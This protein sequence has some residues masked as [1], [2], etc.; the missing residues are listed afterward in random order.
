V[1][2]GRP[3]RRVPGSGHPV[4]VVLLAV[5]LVAA[6]VLATGC[7]HP[8]AGEAVAAPAPSLP[9]RA[10]ELET[11]LV[12]EVPSGLPRLPDEQVRPPAGEKT[13]EDVAGYAEEPAHERAVLEDY[14]Y[15]FGWERFWGVADGALTG[16]F[17]HQ[18]GSRAMAAAYARDLAANDAEFYEGVLAENPPDLPGGCWLLTVEAPRPAS[19]LDGPAAISWCGAG[20]FSVSVTA[21]ADS[22]DAARAEVRELLPQQLERLPSG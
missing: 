2:C 3:G 13:V 5:L 21:V 11:L 15:R 8:V 18:L 20:A 17:L 19:G 4:R 16:V 12:E 1:T 22:V 14:G 7:D 6:V 10:A 9:A